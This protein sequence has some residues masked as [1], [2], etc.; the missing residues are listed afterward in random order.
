MKLPT[1]RTKR[2]CRCWLGCCN[3]YRPYIVNFGSIARPIIDLTTNKYG[4]DISSEWDSDPKYQQAFD[5][6][7]EK[8]CQ[9]PILTL[10]HRLSMGIRPY[11]HCH[12]QR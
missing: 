2:D 9:Y 10:N 1:P 3:Y 12:A 11:A 8:L 4:K 5:T 7:K 6:L